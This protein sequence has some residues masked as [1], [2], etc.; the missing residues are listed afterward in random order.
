MVGCERVLDK[1]ECPLCPGTY[2]TTGMRGHLADHLQQVALFVLSTE[3]DDVSER[4]SKESV[5]MDCS[6]YSSE[7]WSDAESRP[8]PES[9]AVSGTSLEAVYGLS[10]LQRGIT[11]LLREISHILQREKQWRLSMGVDRQREIEPRIVGLQEFAGVFMVTLAEFSSFKEGDAVFSESLPEL[12]VLK[13][14]LEDLHHELTNPDALLKYRLWSPTLLEI[15]KSWSDCMIQFKALVERVR[16][17]DDRWNVDLNKMKSGL[18]RLFW[19]INS[20]V[21]GAGGLSRFGSI[22]AEAETEAILRKTVAMDDATRT[23]EAPQQLPRGDATTNVI[24]DQA[25]QE[26]EELLRLEES[27]RFP[28]GNHEEQLRRPEK[29]AQKQLEEIHPGPE[30]FPGVPERTVRLLD[31]ETSL[32]EKDFSLNFNE[33]VSGERERYLLTS[34]TQPSGRVI[35]WD[36][37]PTHRELWKT[38]HRVPS[39]EY[40]EISGTTAPAS[41]VYL[42]YF[43][44]DKD[45]PLP[46]LQ[47]QS[48]NHHRNSVQDLL[49]AWACDPGTSPDLE[50]LSLSKRDHSPSISL[51]PRLGIHHTPDDEL[52]TPINTNFAPLRRQPTFYGLPGLDADHSAL[53]QPP[54]SPARRQ[55]SKSDPEANS[56]LPDRRMGSGSGANSRPSSPRRNSPDEFNDGFPFSTETIGELYRIRTFSPPPT[57]DLAELSFDYIPGGLYQPVRLLY[58]PVI[59][60]GPRATA[61]TTGLITLTTPHSQLWAVEVGPRSSGH[62]FELEYVGIY[63]LCYTAP[64]PTPSFANNRANYYPAPKRYRGMSSGF[65]QMKVEEIREVAEGLMKL[66]YSEHKLGSTDYRN[67]ALELLGRICKGN[68]GTRAR[69]LMGMDKAVRKGVES[70]GKVGTRGLRK[71]GLLGD[72]G[73]L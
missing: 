46:A 20:H 60:G 45:R 10:E 48:M 33:F 4:G 44:V 69:A 9:E 16:L 54:K 27:P 64:S 31:P 15:T 39:I 35:D 24:L 61:H 5:N 17:L 6:P 19:R 32:I 12:L 59:A 53:S 1:H 37:I 63:R 71:M 65:T 30:R 25:A 72:G 47:G 26:E 7:T 18:E 36:P 23:S 28:G 11:L 38:H 43:N 56:V 55:R 66:R 22:G 14:P 8:S 21:Q 42:P 2:S 67:F 49:D 58:R 68:T 62:R 41:P 40:S 73:L 52:I 70:V 51:S 50:G 29:L 57:L 13:Q 3:Q 34:S